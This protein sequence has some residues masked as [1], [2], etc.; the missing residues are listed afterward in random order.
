VYGGEFQ[1]LFDNAYLGAILG[2]VIFNLL[3]IELY[4]RR[5]DRRIA[6]GTA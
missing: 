2:S 5:R 3:F 4:L 6:A 1:P